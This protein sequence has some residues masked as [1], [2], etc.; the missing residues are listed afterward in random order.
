[1]GEAQQTVLLYNIQVLLPRLFN[2]IGPRWA[3]IVKIRQAPAARS[4]NITILFST[5]SQPQYFAQ[6]C[7]SWRVIQRIWSGRH[8][9][10]HE[11]PSAL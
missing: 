5:S 7:C 8:F 2:G 9:P 6:V 3:R 1:M 11:L 4:A 10:E